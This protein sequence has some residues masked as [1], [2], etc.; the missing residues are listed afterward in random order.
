[1]G[2]FSCHCAGAFSSKGFCCYECK[3]NKTKNHAQGNGIHDSTVN[4]R[5]IEK[6]LV[7]LGFK[8]L[9]FTFLGGLQNSRFIFEVMYHCV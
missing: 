3:E 2:L 5:W 9:P 1:M 8:T 7:Q 4:E 6:Q